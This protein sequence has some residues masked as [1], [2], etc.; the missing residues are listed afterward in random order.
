MRSLSCCILGAAP[1]AL[2]LTAI[3]SRR[4]T[5]CRP[6]MPMAVAM[7]ISGWYRGHH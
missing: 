5:R 6:V 7:A 3:P 2:T 4:D 1:L